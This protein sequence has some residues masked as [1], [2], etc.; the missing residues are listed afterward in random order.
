MTISEKLKKI[1]RRI[2]RITLTTVLVMLSILVLIII[3]IQTRSVQNYGRQKIEAYLENKLHTKVRIGNLYLGL[4]TKIVLKNIYLGDQK[5]DTLLS[6]GNIEADISLFR[7]LRHEVRLND[8]ELAGI[9]VK[10]KRLLP[11]TVFNF[12]FIVDAF[13][14]PDKKQ[15]E[16]KDTTGGFSFAIG[17]IHLHNIRASYRDD[18][19]GNDVSI[20][21]N[22]FKT[23]LKTVDPQN[24]RYAIPDISFSGV[25]A[26]VR[27][28]HPILI[29]KHLA[30]TI[31]RHN[32][33]AQPVQLKL[34]LVGIKDF[35]LDYRNEANNMD[36]V[37]RLGSFE[38]QADSIDLGNI[39][40]KLKKIKLSETLAAVH[41]GVV[42]KKILPVV[43]ARK[44]TI[45]RTG[46]WAFDVAALDLDNIHLRY[47]DDNKKPVKRGIDYNHLDV[48]HL[49]V[50]A[51]A[52]HALSTEYSGNIS[53]IAFDEKSGFVLKKLSTQAAYNDKGAQLKNLIIQ[54]S[55]SEIRSQ[56]AIHYSSAETLRTRPGD[57]QADMLF[58][59]AR[60]AVRDVLV[61]VPGF[62]GQLK[63]NERDVLTLNG[64]LNG[65]LKDLHIPYLE[66]AG[67]GNTS[68]SASGNIRGLP[69]AKKAYFDIV[70]SRLTTSRRDLYRIIPAKSLPQN[71]RIPEHISA[72][73]KF[74]GTVNRFRLALKTNTSNGNA[75]VTGLLDLDHKSYDLTAKTDAADLGYILKQD[76]LFGKITLDATARGSGF[77]PKKMNSVFHVHLENAHIK[78]YAYKGLLLDAELHDGSGKITSS[79]HDPNISYDLQG[80]GRFAEKFPSV[81]I[82]LQLDTLDLLAL[83]LIKD[84]LQMHLVLDG[85]FSSTNPDALQ[86]KMNIADLAVTRAGKSVH[87]DSVHIMAA[88]S[89]TAQLIQ[90]R[91][92]MAD[93][94]WEGK[95]KL[96]Q[97][98]DALRQ[99]INRYYKLPGKADTARVSAEDWRMRIA[100]RASPLVLDLMPPLKGTDSVLGNISFN[101]AT[102]DFNLELLAPKIQVNQQVIHQ[103]NVRA[104]TGRNALDYS[105]AVADAGQKGFQLYQTSVYGKIANDKFITT[106]LL[107]DKKAKPRYRLSGGLSAAHDAIR[108]VF[109]PDSLLL[110]Y[111]AWNIPADNFVQYDSSGILVRNLNLKHQGESIS[112]NS[113]GNTAQSPLDLHFSNFHIHT[114]TQFAEQDSLLMDGLVNGQAEIKNPFNK[115][116]FTADLKI[117]DLA[118]KADTVGN[119]AVKVDNAEQNAFTAHLLLNGRDNDVQVDGK[120]YS[121]ESR[122][123][124]DMKLNRL[125]LAS[126]KSLASGQV[127]DMTGYLKGHLKASGSLDKPVLDGNLS[128]DSAVVIPVITGEPLRLGNDQIGFDHEGFNFSEFSMLDSAGNKA[129]L[130]GNVFTDDFRKYRFDMTFSAENFRVVNAPKEPNRTFYGKLNINADVD[131]TGSQDLPKVTAAIKVNK[132]TDFTLILPSDDPEAVDRQGV[133]VFANKQRVD[134][135]QFKHFLDSLSSHTA[136]KGMDLSAVIETDS[137]AQF[138]LV[139]D[140]R[141]GDALTM[142]GR[143]E[144]SGGI[145]KSG[146]TTLTGNYE[147]DNGSYNLTLSVLHRKFIIQHGSTVTW[148]GEPTKADIN[149]TAI[150]T[151]NTASID[152]VEQQLA[153]RSPEEVNKFKQ[154]LPFQVKLQMT[155]KLLLP[156][157]HFDIALP[158]ALL[159]IWPDVDLKLQQMRTDEAEVN[160]Q[161]FALLLL[162]RFITENPFES[163][164]G[165]TNAG[166]IARQSASKILSDQLNQLAGSLIKG[167]DVNFDLNSNQD[168]TTGTMQNQTQLNV[169]VSKS[170]FNDRIRVS[171][172]S[173][174]QL[175]Q[176]DPNQNAS[177]IA[178]DVNL[179]YKL[180]QDGRYMIR[181]YRK[182]QYES[183][184][185][186]QVIESGL[187]FILTFDYDQFKELFENRKEE[188]KLKKQKRV[189]P[190]KESNSGK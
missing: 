120:Y 50:R 40:I 20:N 7:L 185:E 19:T 184:V 10:I 151:V 56:S 104:A 168:Y 89:D 142:R 3:L 113:N 60:I 95:Y 177:N 188:K 18:A 46:S 92:E 167:V 98:S 87:T 110:N 43:N 14:S 59:H 126:F 22:D 4:P 39:R 63:G 161:V 86:G 68:L 16:P 45:T 169:N 48:N 138:T 75:T 53:L 170:L 147:L 91:S 180:S 114:L 145:D 127:K 125:N 33:D 100:L 157:I 107:K 34:G 162:G 70:L 140:E 32:S 156:Q 5:K 62:S 103:L 27:Q 77:D 93:L 84:S 166:T 61:F 35:A 73:G 74:T 94:D 123:D 143:A 44:D 6:G 66:I 1:I 102:N 65:K 130:D 42:A 155:G 101:S 8:V 29:L 164:A 159:A 26:K 141:N 132:N 52:L 133:V 139:I 55:H 25:S 79:L 108:F 51:S 64:K 115:P 105:I 178:G 118:Y 12:Q 148:S 97:V 154:R 135:V 186:G 119:L 99:L 146:K 158:D 176:T 165:G 37:V 163:A 15:V 179:D 69:D 72:N 144:L 106:L 88:H 122:M 111:D 131:V 23:R 80:E 187:S 58:D 174:F 152:L 54:T 90:L 2:F 83:H 183:V 24:Q 71:I 160:K 21:L 81:K 116:L 49:V 136:L 13:S 137:N 47:A 149:I 173:D 9:T 38:T 181:V 124:L 85:D 190:A 76:S 182:N 11:D 153:G 36:A 171:V 78:T 175:E 57:I 134:T 30:D 128:F 109:N 67:I 189:K 172:G 31:S 96:T 150:Y 129:T 121:G 41:Y 28:Y 17:T 112:V 82:K 117:Q